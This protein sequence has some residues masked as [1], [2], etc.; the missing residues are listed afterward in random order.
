MPAVSKVQ[1][2]LMQAA[3]HGDVPGIKPSVGAEFVGGQSPVGL[4]ERKKKAKRGK[5]PPAMREDGSRRKGW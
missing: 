3:K 2:R 1:F 4:P 5:M